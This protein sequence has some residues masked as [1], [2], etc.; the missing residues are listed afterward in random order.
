MVRCP[1]KSI[2]RAKINKDMSYQVLTLVIFVTL[3]SSMVYAAPPDAF[4]SD[5]KDTPAVTEIEDLSADQSF[6][7]SLFDGAFTYSYPIIVSPG[8]NGLQPS[9]SISYNH[10]R[11]DKSSIV[12]TG[13]FLSENYIQR[14]INYT[15]TNKSDD[16]FLLI[17]N[18]ESHK[19]RYNSSDLRYHTEVESY[20]FIKN[21]T[22]GNNTY[23]PYWFVKK[24]DGTTYRFGY[25]NDSEQLS[26]QENY[27][28]RWYLDLIN[29][30]F[31][32]KIFYFYKEDPS[33]SDIGVTYPYKITYNND[34]SRETEF[35]LESSDRPDIWDFY[36]QGTHTRKSRRLGE[37]QIKYNNSLVRKYTFNYSYLDTRSFLNKIQIYG[38]DNSSLLYSDSYSYY[39]PQKGWHVAGDNWDSP[40]AFTSTASGDAFDLGVRFSDINRDGYLDFIKGYK[41]FDGSPEST[42][43]MINNKTGWE[44]NTQEDFPFSFMMTA[45]YYIAGCGNY[46][47]YGID[48]GMRL[49][50]F[51]NDGF[52][53]LI[54]SPHSSTSEVDQALNNTAYLAIGNY[55]WF[56]NSS[57]A[58][59]TGEG[60]IVR[61]TDSDAFPPI[62]KKFFGL[63][64][65]VRFSDVNG[66][67]FVD[68]V[69]D[70]PPRT[71][72]NNQ[73]GWTEISDW[74]FSEYVVYPG[75]KRPDSSCPFQWYFDM[76]I[77]FIDIN[78]D[79]LED[80]VISRQQ[81]FS[82]GSTIKKVYINNGKNFVEANFSIPGYFI[83]DQIYG[84]P[85]CDTRY[86]VDKGIRFVDVN[87]DGFVDIVKGESNTKEV[88]LN[89]GTGWKL[90]SS[91]VF[92]T[93]FV[94]SLFEDQGVRVAD[95]NGDGF[96]DILK[97][98]SETT[99]WLHNNSKPYYLKQIS[100]KYGGI[101]TIDYKPSTNLNNKGN[102][103]LSDLGFN[104]WVVSNI[105]RDNSIDSPHNTSSII[106]YNYSGGFYD[107]KAKE[108]RGF[109]LV[110]EQ[111]SDKK[112]EHFFHQ[113]EA[114][115]GLEYSYNITDLQVNIYQKNDNFWN[116]TKINDY[117][118][119][120]L[121]EKSESTF[122]KNANPKIKNTSYT[123]DSFGNII[124]IISKGD[125]DKVGDEKYEYFSYLNNSNAWIVDKLKNY[126]LFAADN[127]AKLR[128]TK[129]SYDNLAYGAPPTKGS[130][131]NKE[132]WL[133]G[134]SNPITKYFY[135]N[136]G[137]LV[138]ETNPNN[139]TTQYIYGL[140]DATYTFID[141][142]INAKNHR[143]E[144]LYDL[145][146]GNL[147]SETDSNG[148]I[149]NYT[150]DVFGRKVSEV[151][152]YDSPIYPTIKY[153]YEFDGIAPE[154]IKIL[155]REQNGTSN[156]LDEFK[157]YDGFGRYIQTK[158]ESTNNKQIVKDIYY[159]KEERLEK[160][161]NP[162]YISFYENYSS[163][164]QSINMTIYSYD[165]LDRLTRIIN[166]DGTFRNITYD[167]WNVTLYDENANR[168]D[169]QINTYGKIVQVIEYN[170]G[171]LYRTYYDYDSTDNLISIQD[172]RNNS[173]NYTYDTLGRKTRLN[174]ID[175]GNL[176][177]TYDSAGN[178]IQQN[179][180]KVNNITI[181][182]DELNRKT[183]EITKTL[184][185][186]YIYDIKH[187]NTLSQIKI[188][189]LTI[190]YTYD[191]RLRNIKEIRIIDNIP[192][193]LEFTY[194]S[195]DRE[196]S[197][198]F[199]SNTIKY[200]YSVQ[201]TISVII[202]IANI[203]YNEKNSILNITYYNSLIT[204]YTYKN[205]NQRLTNIT[206]KNIQNLNY[207]YDNVGNIIKINDT[208]N[209]KFISM[210]YDNLDRLKSTNIKDYQN[211]KDHDLNFT[212]NE[213]G[214]ILEVLYN[215]EDY[216][217]YYN[218]NNQKPVHA[219]SRV[220][221]NLLDENKNDTHKFHIEDSVGN[222][223][224]WLGSSGNIVLL[225]QCFSQS[226][227]A[228]N[229]GNSFIIANS[230][231][232]TVAYI[233]STGSLCVEKG[234]CSDSSPSCNP[235]RD[236][237]IIQNS[238][239][240]N[241]S[242]I[243]FSGDLCLIGSL[244]QSSKL[245]YNLTYNDNGNLIF[246][247][248]LNHSYNGFNQLENTTDATTGKLIAEYKYDHE[249]QRYK[250]VQY[251]SNGQNTTTYYISE[252]FIQI[253]NSTGVFNET[254]YYLNNKLIARNDSKNLFFY[255]PDNLGSTALVTNQSGSIVEEEFYLPYGDIYSG[256]EDSRFL[257][258]GKE[259]DK[260]TGLYYYGAR[261]Y[262]PSQKQFIQPDPIIAELYNPQNL[263]RYAYVLNN[264]YKYVDDS[265]NIPVDVVVDV[266]FVV[267]GIVDFVKNP[268]L[269][270]FGYLGADIGFALVPFVP[271]VKRIGEAGKLVK[272][273]DNVGDVS[274]AAN[275][276]FIT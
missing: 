38:N 152:P 10:Q 116:A 143:F 19:L 224:A 25:N 29:D 162:Y 121:L 272:G 117:Y 65:G 119:V 123:Y 207:I 94:N 131:T 198:S 265:G 140:K 171:S 109:N 237:F 89:N 226:T 85:V 71:W 264:P 215:G 194:D 33:A 9:L 223:V 99:T 204:N 191:N 164:N 184:N 196:L 274:D 138:N 128:E 20:L 205:D 246:G 70:Y 233:N 249:G 166:P 58:F 169:Y 13:W 276:I 75:G 41:T 234:D 63:D 273:L 244:V 148:F 66:D 68:I 178:L 21:F 248:G 160:Q 144:Y 64:M 97:T 22:G 7:V 31:D 104:V 228:T 147:L 53:D 107:Y 254:Y 120:E 135:D 59:P 12:G 174:D 60:G 260:D 110:T 126:T 242:Y 16:E 271:N 77:R 37:I 5:I 221:T 80:A 247:Y 157:F 180:T 46:A 122:D 259:K 201:G 186:T 238:S 134:G 183:K 69:D 112:I 79:R 105:T 222:S 266:G 151:L 51:N 136:F 74:L 129:F 170:H 165:S 132:E 212:Y 18:G 217:Y 50:D 188:E 195:L 146:T 92:P 261:Y 202:N 28:T 32:N 185:K 193:T 82:G 137:N 262:Y 106:Y 154:K 87:G 251:N 1:N 155:R 229:D 15:R 78:G 225:G 220:S 103:T 263:N 139:Y 253:R 189:N 177:Y 218:E 23:G 49:F 268:S 3:V 231:D 214:N 149:T 232:N 27:T 150:Y 48:R 115:K 67:G 39:T 83:E 216:K 161:S 96:V 57:W 227:C 47:Q 88:Y 168:K 43:T 76:G 4:Y 30:T 86:G 34:K 100:T 179:Y 111:T 2:K 182:Y 258:T 14:D 173:I 163:P 35:V 153:E 219:P 42:E 211:N 145:G 241:V 84:S 275:A 199:L 36:D 26:N 190:N 130:V 40:Y 125:V 133:N 206:T 257:Y 127:V 230:T 73:K 197:N 267:W 172:S 124:K 209:S 52:E 250:K 90:D 114:R 98:Y 102:D 243:D 239:G 176:T 236:A 24:K 240:E 167:R 156:T 175:L 54:V 93:V 113:D 203:S 142:I 187:N 200:N 269:E 256:E 45:S 44:L 101:I 55:S 56:Q 158:I 62:C 72:I 192:F 11:D 118:I 235:T 91:W 159:D 61:W 255:H 108:F 245:E 210:V 81:E 141:R 252:N 6:S 270:N 17:L 95:V 213:I 208:A 8:A 181:T